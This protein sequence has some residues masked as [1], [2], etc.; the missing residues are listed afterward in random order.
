[1]EYSD[2]DYINEIWF[3]IMELS[4]R[5]RKRKR[6]NDAVIQEMI[7]ITIQLLDILELYLNDKYEY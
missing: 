3:Y 4:H 6:L 1:M 7:N 2:I 5:I